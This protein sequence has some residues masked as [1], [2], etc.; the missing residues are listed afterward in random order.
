V[1]RL[2]VGASLDLEFVRERESVREFARERWRESLLV[3]DHLPTLDLPDEK[4][5]PPM[6]LIVLV[7]KGR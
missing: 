4:E 1:R 7:D 5:E 2:G 3:G 6:H